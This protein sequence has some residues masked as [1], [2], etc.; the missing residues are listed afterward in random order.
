MDNL[1][2]LAFITS[3]LL[4]RT[5]DLKTKYK[6]ENIAIVIAN[7]T[8]SLDSDTEHQSAISDKTNHFP[9]PAVFVYTLANIM[10][11]EIAIRN[12]IK[13][14]NSLFIFENFNAEFMSNYSDILLARKNTNA[15]ISGYVDCI[16]NKYKALL[17]TVE[18]TPGILSI[19]HTPFNLTKL[20]NK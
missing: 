5:N 18:K 13:G 12:S 3:E 19:E 9:S 14:E 17:Y 20:F 8:S 16:E 11:G 2:K 6:E 10:I 7:S 4:M 15:C 1:C